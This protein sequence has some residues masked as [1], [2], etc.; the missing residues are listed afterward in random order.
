MF[1]LCRK[2]IQ[3][4]THSLSIYYFIEKRQQSRKENIFFYVFIKLSPL[5]GQ[6]NDIVLMVFCMASSYWHFDIILLSMP[7]LVRISHMFAFSCSV[8]AIVHDI[9]HSSV[10][11]ICVFEFI[12][13]KPNWLIFALKMRMAFII[14][15]LF[16]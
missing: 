9:R 5:I 6:Q 16:V 15:I 2:F 14:I 7:F 13:R 4:L 11:L 3:S 10:W 1:Q 8:S 12:S